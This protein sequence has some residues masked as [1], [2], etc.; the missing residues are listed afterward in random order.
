MGGMPLTALFSRLSSELN[1][2]VVDKTGLTGLFDV[3]LKYEPVRP[4]GLASAGG[5]DFPSPPLKSAAP[6]QL[7]LRL[8][9][10]NGP[11]D[12]IIIESVEQP[13]PN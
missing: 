3:L 8:E 2:P 12:V 1:A 11:L 6:Q 9:E 13:S 10:V 5:R 4:L 7:G